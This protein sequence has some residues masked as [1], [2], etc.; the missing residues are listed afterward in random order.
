V[1]FE[2]LLQIYLDG[3]DPFEAGGQFIDRGFSYTLAVYYLT[4]AQKTTA[5]AGLR[6]LEAE[7]GRKPCIALEPFKNF[8][9]AEEYHQNYDLKHPE[10]FHRELVESGWIKE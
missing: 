10:E 2:T 3:V 5:E 7:T 4:E 1:S 6:Q 8:Y 9:T